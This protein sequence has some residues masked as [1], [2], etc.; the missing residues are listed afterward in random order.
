MAP[1]TSFAAQVALLWQEILRSD[2]PDMFANAQNDAIDRAHGHD[3]LPQPGFVGRRYQPGGI[4][5]I[6]Q[7]PG[8]DPFG[9]GEGTLD[10]TQYTP[11]RRLR[12]AKNR[13]ETI[14]ASQHLMATLE[15]IMK[16]WNII[17]VVA[18]PL[19][20]ALD[21]DL[22]DVA[23]LNLVKFRTRNSNIGSNLYDK[24]WPSTSQQI[25]LLDPFDIIALGAKTHKQFTRRYTGNATTHPRIPRGRGDTYLPEEGEKAIKI[26]A[27]TISGRH[28][29]TASEVPRRS[30]RSSTT[31]L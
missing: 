8:N 19:L 5:L 27:A 22:D 15:S 14:H 17:R 9:K 24:S 11:L 26:I 2:H 12:D 6:A 7:N 3:R 28:I 31:D 13:R 18:R 23:Y 29:R 4:L 20:H 1:K 16:K 30:P 25:T 10:L 21:L